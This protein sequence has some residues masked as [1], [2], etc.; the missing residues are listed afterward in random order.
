MTPL[1][2]SP[3]FVVTD[4]YKALRITIKDRDNKA[5]DISGG[6]AFL[7]GTGIFTGH[8]PTSNPGE[9]TWGGIP[10]SLVN[11]GTGAGKTGK[12]DFEGLGE[13]LETG[14]TRDRQPYR[15][16]VAYITSGN[17]L[18]WSNERTLVAAAPP[19]DAAVLVA[20]T[21]LYS[22][23][24]IQQFVTEASEVTSQA[25][26]LAAWL[27]DLRLHWACADWGSTGLSFTLDIDALVSGVPVTVASDTVFGNDLRCGVIPLRRNTELHGATSFTAHLYSPTGTGTVAV[28]V[29]VT[30]IKVT[31]P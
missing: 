21:S 14:T 4:S 3:E 19:A 18:S 12:V 24:L 10:G 1:A 17:L 26:N 20:G 2:S 29:F 31:A 8:Q 27:G 23:P 7:F 9:G 11:E 22:V 30:G 16:R 6:S 15:Y 25:E 13:L 28:Q 5:L